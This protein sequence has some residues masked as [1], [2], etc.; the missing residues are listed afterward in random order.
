MKV[1]D[2]KKLDDLG[3]DGIDY[4]DYPDFCDAH[5][6][7]GRILDGG[8]WRD[9]TEDELDELNDDDDLIRETLEKYIY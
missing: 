9:L 3:I 8:N 6:S 5:I 7:A 1:I 2:Y 4:S